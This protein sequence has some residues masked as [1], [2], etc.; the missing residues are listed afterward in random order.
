MSPNATRNCRATSVKNA[1]YSA[2][3]GRYGFTPT[4]STPTG[5]ARPLTVNGSTTAVSGVNGPNG[6]GNNAPGNASRSPVTSSTRPVRSTRSTTPPDPRPV[7]VDPGT[8]A[9][10][11]HTVLGDRFAT[12]P[13]PA[14][15]R[16]RER[17]RLPRR[18]QHL[19]APPGRSPPGCRR[20]R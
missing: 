17:H 3:N 1:R 8:P 7:S 5:S 4:T 11:R 12:R 6:P 2:F 16:D 15:E 13:P 18:G 19:A 14:Q 10:G 9:S 20:P